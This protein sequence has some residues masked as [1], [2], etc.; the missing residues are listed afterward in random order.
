M[1]GD[2]PNPLDELAGGNI[3]RLREAAGFTQ[4]DLAVHMRREGWSWS[5]NTVTKTESGARPLRL[6][7]AFTLAGGFDITV[8]EMLDDEQSRA[9]RLPAAKK[10]TMI[11]SPRRW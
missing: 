8:D 1:Y 2:P 5:A 7:E 9:A 11:L 6:A 10:A 3:R 4:R